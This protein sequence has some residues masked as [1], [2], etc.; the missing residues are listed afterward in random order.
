MNTD[1]AAALDALYAELPTIDCQGKCG[2]SCGPID[3]SLGERERIV[4]LGVNIPRYTVEAGRRWDADMK[5]DT[6]P[7]LIPNPFKPYGTEGRCGVYKVRPMICRL[8]GIV[9][10]D[11]MRCPHGCRP[12]R[13]LTMEE[14][15]EF[16]ARAADIGGSEEGQPPAEV[17]RNL[18]KALGHPVCGPLIR[19]FIA[20]D[21]NHNIEERLVVALREAG[22]SVD[23]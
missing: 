5:V 20:G 23:S 14:S 17:H 9:D 2:N 8:W 1:Q 7:A 19:R 11:N 13:W 15:Y 18:Q 16:L 10:A 4:E 3:M 21:R 12:S 6:C 22:L